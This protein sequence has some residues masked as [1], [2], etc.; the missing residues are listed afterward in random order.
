M[1]PDL[2]VQILTTLH[3]DASE[4][5]AFQSSTKTFEHIQDLTAQVVGNIVAAIF[6]KIK[7]DL[8]GMLECINVIDRCASV[9]PEMALLPS[10]QTLTVWL[11]DALIGMALPFCQSFLKNDVQFSK[12][13]DSNSVSVIKQVETELFEFWTNLGEELVVRLFKVTLTITD[14]ERMGAKE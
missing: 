4:Y 10:V 11:K 6:G 3:K 7:K 2:H 8:F 12:G 9:T 1:S 14:I 13:L 5:E